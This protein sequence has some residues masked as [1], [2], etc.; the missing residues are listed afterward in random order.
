MAEQKKRKVKPAPKVASAAQ[1][2][3]S[4]PESPPNAPGARPPVRGN[5]VLPLG[6]RNYMLLGL[7]VV[8]LIIGYAIMSS[9]DFI[10]A[11]SDQFSLALDVAPFII[12][13]GYAEIIYAIMAKPG[14]AAPQ[15]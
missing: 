7:G 6:K 14:E 12:L 2:G 8:I 10:D 5:E 13:G 15:G 4:A 1:R 11:Q 3:A 9:E